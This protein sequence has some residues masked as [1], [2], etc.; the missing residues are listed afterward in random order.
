MA[1]RRKSVSPATKQAF[2]ENSIALLNAYVFE[3]ARPQKWRS[4]WANATPSAMSAIYAGC[5]PCG[6]RNLLLW[7]LIN[8]CRFVNQFICSAVWTAYSRSFAM[9]LPQQFDAWFTKTYYRKFQYDPNEKLEKLISRLVDF[10]LEPYRGVFSVAMS[11]E[12]LNQAFRFFFIRISNTSLLHMDRADINTCIMNRHMYGHRYTLG[13]LEAELL[14]AWDT[15]S[16]GSSDDESSDSSSSDS[17]SSRS[18][19]P[20]RK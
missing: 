1:H 19:S 20:V 16:G 4:D 7:D 6:K 17:S 13:E 3:P 9:A 10:I 5:D 11:E 15:D 12:P 18:S 2:I 8:R 14:A